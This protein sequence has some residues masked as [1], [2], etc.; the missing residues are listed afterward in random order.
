MKSIY[1]SPQSFPKCIRQQHLCTSIPKLCRKNIFRNDRRFIVKATSLN[2]D[3]SLE[4]TLKLP[5]KQ[6]QNPTFSWA[7][8]EKHNLPTD[9]WIVVK[10]KVYDV[11]EFVEKHPGG[12]VIKEYAGKD[13]SDVFNA[14]HSKKAWQQLSEFY[15]GEIRDS[16][17]LSPVQLEY[18][19]LY[20]DFKREGLFKSNKLYY[21][22]KVMS[23]QC[24]WGAAV[25]TLFLGPEN[26]GTW[27]SAGIAAFLMAVYWQQS[28]WLAHD[29]VH[30]QVFPESQH[31]GTKIGYFL[32]NVCQGFS[33]DWWKQKH[34]V[35]HALPNYVD[36]L[37]FKAVD[38]DIN[39]LPLLSW[40]TEQLTHEKFEQM[41]VRNQFYT[42]IPILLIARVAWAAE[43]LFNS[44]QLA[45]NKKDYIE[46]IGMC[47][48]YAWCLGIAFYT[49]PA[50]EAVGFVLGA[51]LLGGLLLGAVFVISH[52]GMEIL[53]DRQTDFA[54]AQILTTRNIESSLFMD[55]FTGGLNYQIEH[56]L[57]PMMP[58]H[59]LAAASDRVRELC[60]RNGLEYENKSF[61]QGFAS[62]MQTLDNVASHVK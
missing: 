59:N 7:E 49:L 14:F 44:V 35:H 16:N 56:H 34:N 22:W 31:V 33:V 61:G 9:C 3:L 1:L 20:R 37:D 10:N 41:L 48:H 11:S 21:L 17:Q 40:S 38:P 28:G 47:L 15:I 30:H 51:E 50:P 18:Q 5:Q 54:S 36:E 42:F 8:V 45:T 6:L 23:N 13:A 12:R 32:A 46:L 27:P 26:I 55:W 24:I 25:F 60:E 29:F 58:R 53:S 52:N 57:F 4:T 62:I 39:T 19:Q 2:E 43:S